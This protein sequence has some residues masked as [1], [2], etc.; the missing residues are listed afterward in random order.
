[1]RLGL[2]GLSHWMDV[3][4]LGR[5]TGIGIAE[6]RGRL[7]DSAPATLDEAARN[8]AK[9]FGG[10]GQGY[11]GATPLQMANVAAT[12]A[13]NGVWMRPHLIATS[14]MRELE[15]RVPPSNGYRWSDV[16]E[17]VALPIS[18][19]AL[20][21]AQEGMK[22]V[23]NSLAG[24]GR[25]EREDGLIAAGKTGTAQ[26]AHFLIPT[27][28][29]NGKPVL[30][31]KGN[32]LRTA[33]APSTFKNP[34]SLAPWYLGFGEKGTDVKHSWYIGYAPADHPRIAFAVLVEYGGSGGTAAKFI[35]NKILD[36]CIRQGYIASPNNLA[37]GDGHA[38]TERTRAVPATSP[39]IPPALSTIPAAPTT[40]A[41]DLIH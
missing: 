1:D 32:P 14:D 29:E 11:V 34:D 41:T 30:D 8:Q 22:R 28:D 40:N 36:A 10:I 3:F 38:G 15:K 25:L 4:G 9:W 2:D 24:T 37:L 23:A 13:R 33:L 16:P 19:Q 27:L 6:V 17:R 35:A 31:E 39:T 12:I 7:P 18:S 26:A 20:A 5:P 21:A